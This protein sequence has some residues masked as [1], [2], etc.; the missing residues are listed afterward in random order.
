MT[1]CS[2]LFACALF[3]AFIRL[4]MSE[5]QQKHEVGV[6]G[7]ERERERGGG[8]VEGEG[9]TSW[10]VTSQ[11]NPLRCYHSLTFIIARRYRRR[12]KSD[13]VALSFKMFSASHPERLPPFSISSSASSSF[14]LLHEKQFSDFVKNVL[15]S[16]VFFTLLAHRWRSSSVRLLVTLDTRK[17]A[18]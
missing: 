1:V 7:R 8:G 16:I 6:S 9:E 15:S 2:V 17:V 3:Q 11:P 4:D 5:Y 13:C 18:N 12:S 14:F 10:V